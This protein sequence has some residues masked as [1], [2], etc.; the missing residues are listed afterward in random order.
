MEN[1]DC[2]LQLKTL[3]DNGYFTGYASVFDHLDR[4]QDVVLS[5][6]FNSAIKAPK[7]VKLLWQH[8]PATPIGTINYLEEDDYGLYVEAKL[9]LDVQKGREAYALLKNGAINGLSIGY[10][11]KDY[12][13]DTESGIRLIKAVNLYEISVVTFPANEMAEVRTVKFNN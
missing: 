12:V 5:G 11:V 13:I 6:A 9:L 3:A 1:L 10:N 7:T 8:D 4:Q 2:N